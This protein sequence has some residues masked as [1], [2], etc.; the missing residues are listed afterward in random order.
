MAASDYKTHVQLDTQRG[1][2]VAVAVP[3][4]LVTTQCRRAG[5]AAVLAVPVA[6]L[7]SLVQA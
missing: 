7:R 2:A 4:Q 6:R 5:E 1:V 3:E